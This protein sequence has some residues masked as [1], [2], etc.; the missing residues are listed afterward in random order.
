MSPVPGMR[1]FKNR[2]P[3]A[4]QNVGSRARTG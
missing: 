4:S 3:P 2:Y 1:P